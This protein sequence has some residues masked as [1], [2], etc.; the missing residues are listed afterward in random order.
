MQIRNHFKAPAQ[1][2]LCGLR[3]LCAMLFPFMSFSHGSQG[4]LQ[5]LIASLGCESQPGIAVAGKLE[6][7]FPVRDALIFL[8]LK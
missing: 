8:L 3:D 5:L 4:V 1:F 6:I 2:L 7:D